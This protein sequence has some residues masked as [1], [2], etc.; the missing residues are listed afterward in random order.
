MSTSQTP[1]LRDDN[2][3]LFKPPIL[4]CSVKAAQPRTAR[5]SV[6]ISPDTALAPVERPCTAATGESPDLEASPSLHKCPAPGVNGFSLL[7]QEQRIRRSKRRENWAPRTGALT[8][9]RELVHGDA[10]R[11]E[12][13]LDAGQ[14][15][16]VGAPAPA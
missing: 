7:S 8:Y 5:G 16:H 6:P 9:E 4:W 14:P 12:V 10:L 3:L 2:F 15:L 1:E 11:S 13:L